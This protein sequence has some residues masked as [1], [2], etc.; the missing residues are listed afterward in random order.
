M[1]ATDPANCEVLSKLAQRAQREATG[2]YCGYT[3]KRQPI[4]TN[5]LQSVG[6]SMNYLTTG[7]ADKTAGQKWHRITH[8]VL[9]DFHHRMMTRTAPEESNLAAYWNDHDP[10]A[11]EF[12]RTYMLIDFQGGQLLQRLKDEERRAQ[13]K[14]WQRVVPKAKDQG[15][16][17]RRFGATLCRFLR[18]SRLAPGCLLSQCLGICHAVGGTAFAPTENT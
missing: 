12:T 1:W 6:E 10:T 4:G 14:T 7:M 3:F 13:Q 15:V 5:F 2:Y 18:V 17:A 11:A 16:R 8:R 9:T